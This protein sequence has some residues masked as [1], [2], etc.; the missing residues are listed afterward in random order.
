MSEHV[1]NSEYAQSEFEEHGESWIQQRFAGK[2]DTI[3][4]VGS[5]IGE[6]TKMAR[7]HHPKAKI[8]MFEIVPD[9]YQKLLKNIKIDENMIP[10]SFGLL[11]ASGPVAMKHKTT[12]DAL[13]TIVTDL[14]LDDSIPIT[15][16]AFTGDDYVKSRRIDKIDYLK[17]D[18]EGAEGKVFKG[19]ENTLREGKV[20]IL[21][22][23]YSFVCVLTKW[24]LIDSYK[25]LEPLGFKLG[26]LGKDHIR[27]HDYT[28]VDE[29][30][31]GPEY[32]A[33]HESAWNEFF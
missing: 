15:G 18:T 12:Y 14:R 17:I 13:S 1:Y 30:F 11:D 32:V 5:N 20:K 9:T 33:V 16:L 21:Q 26:K 19:F 3:F 8:H 24:M 6:W 31:V 25:F 7:L 28:L 22:F 2:F 27:F 10:N 4:D 23:E 29:T